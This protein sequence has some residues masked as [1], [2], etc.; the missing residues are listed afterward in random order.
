MRFWDIL[1]GAGN[2]SVPDHTYA[3]AE[4]FKAGIE[5]EKRS[6]ARLV[7]PQFCNCWR[8]CDGQTSA[9]R[10]C[11]G[12]P[13]NQERTLPMKEKAYYAVIH[14]DRIAETFDTKDAARTRAIETAQAH[15]GYTVVVARIQGR[16]RVETPSI[17]IDYE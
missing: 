7:E 4:G 8:V 5:H 17:W 1:L 2:S 10:I 9:H 15:P 6:C 3:W 11:C 13:R 14:C 16:A 12:F